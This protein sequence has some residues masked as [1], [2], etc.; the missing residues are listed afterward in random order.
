MDI[1]LDTCALNRL[2]DDPSQGRIRDEAA[3][4]EAILDLIAS[5]E[6]SWSASSILELE[7]VRNPDPFQREDSLDLL[8]LATRSLTPDAA[9]IRSATA[10]RTE[11]FGDFDALHLALAD[12]YRV[13]VLFT[14]DDRF[15]HRAARRQ[16]PSAVSVTNPVDWLRRRQPWLIK[17]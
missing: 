6:L 12:Q 13:A 16:A 17:R 10:L 4:V 11:G 3:A 7:L 9:T 15:L 5:G 8:Q 1:Y 2:K 14:V